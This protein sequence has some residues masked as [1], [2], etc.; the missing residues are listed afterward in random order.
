M[1][2]L[3]IAAAVLTL[4]AWPAATRATLIASDSFAAGVG[5]DDYST[6]QLATQSPTVGTTGFDGNDIWGHDGSESFYTGDL[7]VQSGSLSHALVTGSTSEGRISTSG[8]TADR[9]VYRE[10]DALDATDGTYYFSF[11][12]QA[13]Y[14]QEHSGFGITRN[15]PYV[16]ARGIGGNND[17]RGIHGVQ[18]GVHSQ[19]IKLYI[20]GNHQNVVTDFVESESYFV[21]VR[22]DNDTADDDTITVSIYN[23][24]NA[25]VYDSNAQFVTTGEVSTD[26]THLG[27]AKG[28]R[29]GTGMD[30]DEFRLGT[31]LGDV[32]VPEPAT[33]ALL[34]LGVLA[35]AGRRRS[36]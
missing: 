10:V 20:D 26:L 15:G 34:G 8:G 6:G 29:V 9:S 13:A 23:Q 11:V 35:I 25:D 22:I 33:M 21:L 30:V 1:L 31:L 27:I 12:L 2:R 18:V 17:D 24:G 36:A 4:A 14:Q 3:T 28:A 7:I 19:N 32:A 5:G 16:N